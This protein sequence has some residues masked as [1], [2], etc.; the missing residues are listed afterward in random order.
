MLMTWIGKGPFGPGINKLIAVSSQIIEVLRTNRIH[1]VLEE[2]RGVPSREYICVAAINRGRCNDSCQ[3]ETP[4]I[5]RGKLVPL[6]PRRKGKFRDNQHLLEKLC[7]I[8][9]SASR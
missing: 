9:S 4:A 6:Q 8:L 1:V 2:L 3:T 7:L 5:R